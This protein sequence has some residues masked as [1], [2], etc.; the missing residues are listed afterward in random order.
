MAIT[1]KTLISEK[2]KT[3][4]LLDGFNPKGSRGEILVHKLLP[5]ERASQ[6]LLISVAQIISSLIGKK[7][8][9]D[10]IKNQLL[11]SIAK[12][13]IDV[14]KEILAKFPKR[15]MIYNSNKFRFL[16]ESVFL[17]N[18]H[19]KRFYS[20]S[21]CGASLNV[22]FCGGSNYIV[23]EKPHQ[24]LNHFQNQQ[25]SQINQNEKKKFEL[26]INCS[27]WAKANY[28]TSLN[29]IKLYILQNS[30][31]HD[32]G[33]NTLEIKQIIQDVK[34]N[35]PKNPNELINQENSLYNGKKWVRSYVQGDYPLVLLLFDEAINIA[36]RSYYLFVDGTFKI[37]PKNFKQVLNFTVLDPVSNRYVPICHIYLQSN[38]SNHYN[39]AFAELGKYINFS[40]FHFCATDFEQALINTAIKYIGT[41]KVHGCLFHYRQALYRRYQKEKN[42]EKILLLLF[43]I[44]SFLPFLDKD[45]F[46]IITKFIHSHNEKFKQYDLYYQHFWVKKYDLIEKLSSPI[47]IFTNDCLESY[48]ALLN[49]KIST[50]HPSL[51]ISTKILAEVDDFILHSNT[52]DIT[53]GIVKRRTVAWSETCTEIQRKLDE[54]YSILQ[55]QGPQIDKSKIQKKYEIHNQSGAQFESVILK[56]SCIDLFEETNI[57]IDEKELDQILNYDILKTNTWDIAE[58]KNYGIV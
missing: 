40:H 1:S 31:G 36:Q 52:Y 45:Q 29:E 3:K 32:Y 9:R 35:M 12:I 25:F 28:I 19:F 58:K 38:T 18:G 7:L 48:H 55:I 26:L 54:F 24:H 44:F 20:C 50:P 42:H 51:N 13:S 17:Q 5:V 37:C 10:Y 23:N 15:C 11:K 33:I 56:S 47:P 16:S 53:H 14:P 22:E 30:Q 6:N 2:E 43:E 4:K 39:A 21:T 8:K 46:N 49:K 27:N 41:G 57:N 34:K